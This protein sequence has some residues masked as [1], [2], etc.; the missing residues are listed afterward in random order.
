MALTRTVV[1]SCP[2][3]NFQQEGDLQDG[4]VAV[5]AKWATKVR[6][7]WGN[8]TLEQCLA[9]IATIQDKYVSSPTASHWDNTAKTL[10]IVLQFPDKSAADAYDVEFNNYVRVFLP[11]PGDTEWTFIGV[12]DEDGSP[13]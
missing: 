4:Q 3:G 6:S 9:S 8:T 2:S 10:T 5:R 7:T 11:A 13:A 12:T 1:W